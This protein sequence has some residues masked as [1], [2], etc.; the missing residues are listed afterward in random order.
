[1]CCQLGQVAIYRRDSGFCERPVLG[2]SVAGDHFL[3]TLISAQDKT[4]TLTQNKMHVEDAAIYDVT[5]D[6]STLRQQL[7]SAQHLVAENLR[8]LPAVSAICNA[9]SFEGSPSDSKRNI[10]GDATG[11]EPESVSWRNA[12]P[13]HGSCF[14]PTPDSAILK[15][16]DDLVSSDT[17]RARWR[18]VHK[19]PFNSKVSQSN[20]SGSP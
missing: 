12:P 13:S 7:G 1:M 19:I 2:R 20:M 18:H 10:I 5:F 4:G 6:V 16:S 8:Q 3:P 17:T 9:A 11:K 14:F 15:F